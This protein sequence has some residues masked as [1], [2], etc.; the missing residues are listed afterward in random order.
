MASG[1]PNRPSVVTLTPT[2]A[3]RGS[4][5]T[6]SGQLAKTAASSNPASEHRPRPRPSSHSSR[7]SSGSMARN[8]DDDERDTPTGE[9]QSGGEQSSVHGVSLLL[10]LA[11]Q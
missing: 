11:A 6:F 8:P 7:R 1:N 9:R 4:V 2:A 10:I 5:W 3:Q